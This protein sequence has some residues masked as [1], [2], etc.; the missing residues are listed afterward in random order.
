MVGRDDREWGETVIAYLVPRTGATIDTAAL[1]RFCI[2]HIARFKRPRFYRVIDDL[3]K[4]N[5]GKVLKRVLRDRE[6]DNDR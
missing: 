6:N 4:N 2:D 3:P 5:Y 1:D